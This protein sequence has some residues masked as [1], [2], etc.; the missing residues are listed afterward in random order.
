MAFNAIRIVFEISDTQ[1]ASNLLCFRLSMQ[2]Q[3]G[4]VVWGS[5]PNLNFGAWHF[6]QLCTPTTL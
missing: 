1:L 5:L 4:F 6:S 3:E 2:R